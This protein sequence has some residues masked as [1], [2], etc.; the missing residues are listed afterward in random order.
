MRYTLF[1]HYAEASTA[2]IG[3]E[4]IEA[5][6]NA[7]H[8]YVAALDRAG[9][10]LSAEVL[11]PSRQTATVRM[12][13]GAPRIHDGP[14]SESKEQVGGTFVLDVPDRESALEW[15]AQCPAA[16]WGAVEVRPVA[17]RVVDGRWV[18]A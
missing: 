12:E 13:D 7:M 3:E 14:F 5:G 17:V 16:A 18:E 9:V 11:Q 15:A 1:L 4:A 8:A 10:L 2:D 6:K